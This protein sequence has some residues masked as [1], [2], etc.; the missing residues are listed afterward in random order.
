MHLK[1]GQIY[2]ITVIVKSCTT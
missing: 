1:I 2:K